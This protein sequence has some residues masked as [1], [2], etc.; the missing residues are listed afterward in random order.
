MPYNTATIDHA[1]ITDNGLGAAGGAGT[2]T[3][4]AGG[5]NGVPASGGTASP[6][7][8]GAT[9]LGGAIFSS[10][11]T[12]RNSIVAGNASPACHST[13]PIGAHDI[14]LGDATCPG[15]DANPLLAALA[16]NGGPSQTRIPGPGSPAIDA[17]P[18]DA[19]CA[20]TDQ[21]GATRP[22]GAGCEIG[23]YE[24]APPQVAITDAAATVLGTVNPNARAATYH[25]DYGTGT[26]YGSSTQ[27]G[28]L[29]AGI[30]PV[31]VSAALAGLAAGTTYHVRL[32]ASN[33]DG[34][35]LGEDR[36]FMTSATG[37]GPGGGPGAD[38]TAPVILSASVKPKTLRRKRGT[39]FR[40]RLSEAANVAFTI[41]RKKGKRYVSATRF[42]KTSK[43]G[44]NTRRFKTRKLKPGRYRATLVATDAAGNRSKA[45]RLTFR[46][47]R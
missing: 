6:G 5:V 8:A 9:G 39:T 24:I 21:R 44:A 35:T 45:K 23:A 31:A 17:V 3:A 19:N 2:A 25:F 15:A 30:E 7:T 1:T 16:D 37:G 41:Q 4:G 38:T 28:S 11:L 26:A 34:T 32:V 10:Q 12:L 42:R 22:H 47:K 46:I 43:A 27:E 33:A 13:T 36:T 29:P 14:S 40:Y 18:A 20:A